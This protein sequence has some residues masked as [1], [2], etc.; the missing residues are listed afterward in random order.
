MSTV[1]GI[2]AP[3]SSASGASSGMSSLS[4]DEFLKLLFTE[5]SN[6]DPLQPNDTNA[7]LQQLANIRSIQS[8][9]D[10]VDR[11]GEVAG[12]NELSSGAGLIGRTVSG[13]SETNQRVTGIVQSASR[14]TDGVVLTIDGG[15]RVPMTSVDR[16]LT[17][18]ATEAGA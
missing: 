11:L 4:S 9:V 14:T 7:M 16:V 18:N 10:L 2:S 3:T 15:T 5:L 1:D 12:Q 17:Q 8:D 13:L 6:Q